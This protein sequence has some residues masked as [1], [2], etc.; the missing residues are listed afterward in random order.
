MSPIYRLSALLTTALTLNTSDRAYS[1]SPI[2]A[3][4][5]DRRDRMI[6]G[7]VR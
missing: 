5:E 4:I 2:D 1:K 3:N 6:H 7:G